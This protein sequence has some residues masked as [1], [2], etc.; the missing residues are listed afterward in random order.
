MN[1]TVYIGPYKTPLEAKLERVVSIE[2]EK[3]PDYVKSVH[4][5]LSASAEATFEC[6]VNV[7]LLEKLVG[8]DLASTRDCTGYTLECKKP[9]PVQI[10]RHKK[11]R[12]NKKWAKRYGYVTKFKNIRITDVEVVPHSETEFEFQGRYMH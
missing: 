6:E 8:V 12:I 11:K 2:D 10:R 4:I 9:Y 3:I 1:G 7:P 5:P